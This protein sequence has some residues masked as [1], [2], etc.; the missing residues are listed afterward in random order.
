MPLPWALRRGVLQ[1]RS[2]GTAMKVH[3]VLE[4]GECLILG[5]LSS[6]DFVTLL[7]SVRVA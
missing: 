1:R 7:S 2:N 6:R 4:F 3:G 5:Y